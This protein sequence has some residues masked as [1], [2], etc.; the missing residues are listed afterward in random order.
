MVRTGPIVYL[1]PTG[2]EPPRAAPVGQRPDR[3]Q[4][5]ARRTARGGPTG[6]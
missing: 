2:R 5:G 1:Y 6:I 3:L 4:E